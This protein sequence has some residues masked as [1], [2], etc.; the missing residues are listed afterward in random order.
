MISFLLSVVITIC[1]SFNAL[2]SSVSSLLQ[3]A[4]ISV[5]VFVFGATLGFASMASAAIPTE[6]SDFITALGA[7]GAIAVGLGIAAWVAYK[8]LW[9][10]WSMGARVV[11]RVFGR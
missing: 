4:K 2:V 9:I 6:I 10:A 7:D 1:S 8:G 11:G 5:S 3:K